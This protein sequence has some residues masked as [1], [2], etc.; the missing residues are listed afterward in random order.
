M[1]KYSKIIL[2]IIM[3][4]LIAILIKPQLS[5]EAKAG[6]V[7]DVNI[8]QVDGRPLFLGRIKVSVD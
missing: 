8:V 3:V 7:T 1:D 6:A 4:L 5:N 2:T